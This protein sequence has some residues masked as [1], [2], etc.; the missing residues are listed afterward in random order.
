MVVV[1]I[2]GVV[3]AGMLISLG[4]TGRDSQLE[5]ER[6]RLS[7]LIDYVRERA[8]LQTIEYGL[9]CDSRGYRFVLYDTRAAAW[10]IDPLDDSLRA[11]T[12]PA[13]LEIALTVEDR[14]IVLPPPADPKGKE[15]LDLTPQV[16]LYSSG[17]LTNFKLRLSRTGTGRSALLTGTVT[18]KLE[19]GD[20][21]EQPT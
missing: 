21:L 8:A 13:G 2:I 3:I 18:G 6:D 5:Q 20:I 15:P 14:P 7:A 19:V 9:R 10:R 11:R 17:E 4:A 1:V 16:M 12:L